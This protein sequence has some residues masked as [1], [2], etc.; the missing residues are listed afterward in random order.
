MCLGAVYAPDALAAEIEPAL[1]TRHTLTT[2]RGQGGILSEGGCLAELRNQSPLP[3]Q[4][5]DTARKKE[6]G[7]GE[8]MFPGCHEIFKR[9]GYRF[10]V[11]ASV[12]VVIMISWV[13]CLG[14]LAMARSSLISKACKARRLWAVTPTAG[15]P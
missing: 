12:E 10:S 7:A 15:R 8:C 3:V 9:T 1:W 5:L 2:A 4:F 11:Q 6:S 14:D 13:R